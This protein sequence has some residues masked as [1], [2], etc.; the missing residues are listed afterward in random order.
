MPLGSPCSS[1]SVQH[2]VHRPVSHSLVGVHPTSPQG[3]LTLLRLH[4]PPLPP[5]VVHGLE[6]LTGAAPKAAAAA[7]EGGEAALRAV[8]AA[9][10]AAAPLQL[11]R[12]RRGEIHPLARAGGLLAEAV[13]G[14]E[15]VAAAGAPLPTTGGGR[16]GRALPVLPRGAERALQRAPPSAGVPPDPPLPRPRL[17][18]AL[19][20]VEAVQHLADAGGLVLGLGLGLGLRGAL[21]GAHVPGHRLVL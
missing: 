7:P 4:L 17:A 14:L 16:G 2:L 20:A 8:R 15:Q 9:R 11:E 19:P 18:P 1:H 12:A 21:E 5:Q 13:D 3:L 6:R 10:A